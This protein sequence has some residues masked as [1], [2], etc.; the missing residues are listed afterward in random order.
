[1]KNQ[2]E[3]NR[4]EKENRQKTLKKKLKLSPE[5]FE[6]PQRLLN[7]VERLAQRIQKPDDFKY[8]SPA[9]QVAVDKARDHQ[10]KMENTN[11]GPFEYSTQTLNDRFELAEVF[12]KPTV[13]L[14]TLMNEDLGTVTRTLFS[15]LSKTHESSQNYLSAAVE[16]G[17]GEGG[18]GRL[19]TGGLGGVILGLNQGIIDTINTEKEVWLL[20]RGE[21]EREMS[22]LREENKKCYDLIVKLSKNE[23]EG[24]RLVKTIEAKSPSKSVPRSAAKK[25]EDQT[26]VR[27]QGLKALTPNQLRDTISD[28]MHSKIEFDSKNAASRLPRETLEQY[29]YTYLTKKYGLKNIVVAWATSIIAMIGQH[30]KTDNLVL[31]FGKIL[32]NEVE[33]EFFYEQEKSIKTAR[34][35]LESYLRTKF[36]LKSI[37]ELKKL[38]H[39]I[40]EGL[41]SKSQCIDVVSYLYTG[42]D[43]KAV[44]LLVD[45]LF[46]ESYYEYFYLKSDQ[47]QVS[48]QSREYSTK[49]LKRLFWTI[50]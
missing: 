7:L 15:I 21:M 41:I 44:E 3:V 33:E 48:R 13:Q 24:L 50:N 14:I 28:I 32:R 49:A 4:I 20:R 18:L 46:A 37:G 10:R 38:M 43:I 9:F 6:D 47:H 2:I 12:I 30:S 22:A 11:V 35:L 8:V 1:M 5:D 27:V 31:V 39:E 26:I 16:M 42:K 45:H 17:T 19:K 36:P 23:A 29:L 25:E 40:T 34:K